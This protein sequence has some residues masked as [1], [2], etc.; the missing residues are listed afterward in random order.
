MSAW[1]SDLLLISSLVAAVAAVAGHIDFFLESIERIMLRIEC[2]R[3]DK[4]YA[5]YRGL[6]KSCLD[7]LKKAFAKTTPQQPTE[8]RF[9]SGFWLVYSS[10]TC[11]ILSFLASQIAI[12]GFFKSS[13]FSSE[14]WMQCAFY[15]IACMLVAIILGKTAHRHFLSLFPQFNQSGN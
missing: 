6:F 11:L 9:Q 8:H 13:T 2:W 1:L 14:I 7:A 10:I 4:R 3:N 5:V 15:F 12:L